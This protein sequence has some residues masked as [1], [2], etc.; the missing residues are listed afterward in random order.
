MDLF[1]KIIHNPASQWHVYPA[2]GSFRKIIPSHARRWHIYPAGGSF[3]KDHTPSFQ[4]LTR[5][6][7]RWI[8]LKRSYTALGQETPPYYA[9]ISDY[10]ASGSLQKDHTLFLSGYTTPWSFSGWLY[11]QWIFSEISYTVML[12]VDT[13]IMPVDLSKKIILTFST[14]IMP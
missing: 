10:L 7:R 5:L 8:F 9:F 11:R 14:I 6:S 3:W 13:F 2:D 1:E 4:A 12:R